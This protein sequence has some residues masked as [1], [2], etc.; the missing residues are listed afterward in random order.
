VDSVDALPAIALRLPASG[1]VLVDF[2]SF[3]AAS[4]RTGSAHLRVRLSEF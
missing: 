4:L 3:L 2:D 1:V